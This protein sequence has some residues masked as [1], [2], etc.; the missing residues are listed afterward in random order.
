MKNRPGAVLIT[1]C[2]TGIGRAT[3]ER[4]AAAGHTIY[5]TARNESSI[6]DLEDLGCRTLALD[7]TDEASMKA[8][9]DTVVAEEGAVGAL[10]NNAGYSQSGA[11]EAVAM[12]DGRRQF[13]AKVFG[14]IR[15]S[16][17]V[18]PA[19]GVQGGYVRL[20]SRGNTANEL[21]H[22]IEVEVFGKPV[23]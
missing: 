21:N 20:Y 23:K 7:V 8:A 5:A 10:V 6:E 15:R 19:K 9:V 14:L 11:I 3:A 4:L 17:L 22:Y 16:Q 13:E 2:S 12:E 18:L 1:G